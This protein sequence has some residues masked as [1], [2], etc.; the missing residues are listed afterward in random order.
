MPTHLLINPSHRSIKKALYAR[1]ERRLDGMSD[2]E[3]K[4]YL[5]DC[6]YLERQRFMANPSHEAEE[7]ASIEALARGI[8][9]GTDAMREAMLSLVREYSHEIHNRFSERTFATAMKLAPAALKRVLAPGE[10][11]VWRWPDSAPG[12][13]IQVQGP[14]DKIRALSKTHTLVYAPTHVSNLDS[15]LIGY[16]LHSVGL[17]PCTYGAGLNLFANPAMSFFMA[18]LGAY[19]VDRRK[20]HRLY[21]DVLKAYSTELISRGAHSLF[22]PGG[23]RSRS[24]KVE[25]QVKRGLLG[26]AI[27]AWQEGLRAEE[28]GT[29]VLVIPCTLSSSLVLEAET[30]IEDFLA[31]EGKSRYI[32]TD[33]EFSQPT[34]VLKFVRQLLDLD[35]SVVVRF[36]EPLDLIGNQVTS[37]GE[38]I[39]GSGRVFDRRKYLCDPQGSVVVDSQRDRVYTDHLA[40]ALCAAYQRDTVALSTHV[41]AFA[42][43]TC[44]A[45]RYPH[46]DQ[47][48]LVLL[49]PFERWIDRTRLLDAIAVLLEQIDERVKAGDMQSLLPGGKERAEKTLTEAITAFACAHSRRA[50]AFEDWRVLVDPKL[51]LYYGNRISTY[52]LTIEVD[53]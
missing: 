30:L 5:S 9:E 53:A 36:G 40:Q 29:D 12:N 52:G 14:L 11:G 37:L 20:R 24:G 18:R 21:K 43:W 47:Y 23:T 7:V 31:E 45:E 10:K 27:A 8:H 46:L 16:A 44:L 2:A 17:P 1:M 51:A 32:I 15:P 38:S 42:G 34:T 19:T 25:T 50:M 3:I 26:T 39:D 6:V 28:G 35:A 49:A 13:H 48:Q 41:A 4:S 33:D 22:Y